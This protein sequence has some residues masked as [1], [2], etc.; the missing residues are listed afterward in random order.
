M[1]GRWFHTLQRLSEETCS[2]APTPYSTEVVVFYLARWCQKKS[3][4]L[5]PRVRA[6]E[7]STLRGVAERIARH[8][9]EYGPFVERLVA[10]DAEAL[11]ELRRELP[12]HAFR[13]H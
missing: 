12:G 5:E 8:L 11:T 4:T 1:A 3:R 13:G 7:Q 9:A 6:F 2:A 10:G